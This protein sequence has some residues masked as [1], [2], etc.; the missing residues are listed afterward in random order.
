MSLTSLQLI[1]LV[2]VGVLLYYT[3]CKKYQWQL[4]LVLSYIYYFASGAKNIIFILA[5]TLVTYLTAVFIEKCEDKYRKLILLVALFVD[6]GILAVLKYT[7][8]VIEIINDLSGGNISFVNLLL[9]LGISFY[10]FQS[11]GYVLDVYW[12]K[13]KAEKN[14]FKLALFVAYFPQIMQG[15]ISRFDSLKNE[16]FK[17]HDIS[18]KNIEQ[19][20][21]L[22]L[23]GLIKKMLIADNA[24]MYVN[25]T[26]DKYQEFDGIVIVA[27]LAYSL[28]LYG[29][30]SGGIDVVRGISSLFDVTLAKNFKQP[31]FAKSITDFWHRWH[32][33]LGT[34]MKDYVFYPVTLSK[35]MGKFSKFAKKKFGKK[36]G[37][38]LPICIANIIVF[39]VVGVW[40]GAAFKYIVYGL[41]NGL[42]IGFSGV[43]ADKYRQVKKKLN[44]NDK[45]KKFITFQI[46]RTF[47]LVNISW[48]FDRADTVKQALVMLKNMFTKF[49]ISPLING[50]LFADNPGYIA[51]MNIQ[52]VAITIGVVIVLLVSIFEERQVDVVSKITELPWAVRGIGYLVIIFLLP[53]IGM[54]P[55]SVGG[56][57]YAQF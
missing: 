12:K 32:I 22:I 30:F 40:H 21:V 39:T 54:P 56:F 3:V 43:M 24:A 49:D 36:L 26:F 42:I 45:S 23:Y 1:G 27:V 4:L 10:T 17:K 2:A 34:W 33:T 8:F 48:L 18:F 53:M 7:N 29:D 28:Q 6:F 15:P 57:I 44:I 55:D 5:T 41:Y 47:V 25:A 50:S 11:T 35:W 20:L 38:S 51:Y 13:T 19:S 31:Y 37:R 16:L 52:M 9:P 14:V 46:I